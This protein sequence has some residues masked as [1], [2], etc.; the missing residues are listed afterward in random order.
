MFAP[1]VVLSVY[2]CLCLVALAADKPR[3]EPRVTS[4]HPSAL[5]RGAA[6]TVTVRGTGLGGAYS[7]LLQGAPFNMEIEGSA[8]E[9]PPPSSRSKTPIDLVRIRV[10]VEHDAQP[11]RH[12]FR[13]VTPN[14]VSNA[15][16]L[17]ITR[18]PVREEA[19]EGHEAPESAVAAGEFPV[20]IAG[21]ISQRGEAD[22][23]S[24]DAKAGEA[25]SFEVVSGVPSGGFD[26]AIT[27]FE[28]SGSWFDPERVNRIAFNDE[29]MW[30]A[31]R[32][33]DAQLL[34]RFARDG[35]YFV[36]VEAFSGLGG[37]DFTYQLR[38][39]TGESKWQSESSDEWQE[40]RFTRPLSSGRLNEL[41]VRGGKPPKQAVIETYRAGA[42]APALFKL[43]GTLDGVLAAP[44]EV[45]RARFQIDGPRD[46]AIEVETPAAAPP[47]FNPI[48]RLLDGSGEEVATNVMAGVGACSGELSK[49]LQAKTTIPLR[50]PG[51]YTVEIRDVTS[52]LGGPEFRYRVQVRPQA[53]HVGEV[54]IDEDRLN[55]APGSAKA[56]RVTF[57]REEDYQ[58]AIAVSADGL[59]PGVRA[60]PGADFEP[61]RDPLPFP[62]RRER[63][64][65]RSERT[66]VVFTAAADA[67]PMQQPQI[68]R[69][70]VLPVVDGK[71]GEPLASKEIPVMVVRK[72]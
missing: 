11:S 14:G 63:Y 52:D 65:P 66:V 68:A 24:F 54:G 1:W 59:P 29:P 53:P 37:P 51:E 7:F 23:Y 48:V 10:S 4:V 58:G 17:H 30:A 34:H 16:P 35:R 43:P 5:Q 19:D 20:V 45:H 39:R 67:A 64:T 38:I 2:G 21:R 56:V 9:P 32:P 46:I 6:S 69:I 12:D 13:L 40:R 44:G 60:L 27:I 49:S 33:T 42:E 47:L 57:D 25:I 36:R 28:R 61:D 71:P 41:A 70:V 15:I 22:Y 55:L 8:T 72:P 3:V 18:D 26:P 31:G 50:N 62:G